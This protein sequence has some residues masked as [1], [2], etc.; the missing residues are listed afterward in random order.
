[1][2]TDTTIILVGAGHAHLHV[3]AHARD[4]LDR[5]CR[6]LL[7]DPGNFWYSGLA[8]GVLGGMYGPEEDQLDVARLAENQGADY[9]QARV[10]RVDSAGRRVELSDGRLLAYDYLSLNV[11][12]GVG[13][14]IPGL[15]RDNTV[16]AVKPVENLWRLRQQ[17]ESRFR[18]GQ[19]PRVAVVGGGASGCEVAANLLSLAHRCRQEPQVK[20]LTGDQG[21]LPAAPPGASKSLKKKLA[22][23]GLRI[24]TGAR[25]LARK[26]GKL[27][28]EDGA[29][30]Q[31]DFV[32]LA[33]GLKAA[34]LVRHT[35]LPFHAAEGLRV[36]SKLHS[37]EDNRVFA[38]G[39]C[40]AMEGYSLPKLGVFGVR[41]AE[42]IRHNL[43]ASLE[44]KALREYRPQQ[45]Y[46]SIL[47]LGNGTALS[48]RGSLWWN[49]RSSLWL[50]NYLDHSFLQRYRRLLT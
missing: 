38:A 10:S 3:L 12:S 41:Q 26:D 45:R 30:L 34:S 9:L 29:E 23:R 35:G 48:I 32:V 4:F 8:T 6:L 21:L 44:G 14:G 16:W 28:L 42:F 19:S 20:L 2:T 24:H 17:L 22:A 50:K 46:L 43:L 31:A 33:T 13:T 11:G 27:V 40:A 15:E 47:N 36:N 37:V 49:G 5:G 7:I 18:A 1:M 39:D 25:V